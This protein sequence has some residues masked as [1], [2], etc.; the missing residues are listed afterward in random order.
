MSRHHLCAAKD[1]CGR[2]VSREGSPFDFSGTITIKEYERI[3][4]A[5]VSVF[6]YCRPDRLCKVRS[7]V[8]R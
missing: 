1:G 7:S 8:L 4:K 3:N 6:S 2:L 5:I